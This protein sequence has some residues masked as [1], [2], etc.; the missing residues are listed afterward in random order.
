MILVLR[1]LGYLYQQTSQYEKSLKHFKKML[2]LAW[3]RSN[4]K[5]ELFAYQSIS[6]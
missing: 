3:F 4:V 6:L 5:M 1:Q 2:Y